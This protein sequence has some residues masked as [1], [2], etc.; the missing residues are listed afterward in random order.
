MVATPDSCPLAAS[1][2]SCPIWL[3][4]AVLDELSSAPLTQRVFYEHFTPSLSVQVPLLFQ[5]LG[6]RS[7]ELWL[8]NMPGS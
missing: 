6:L 7:L 8:T 5:E 2:M 1:L 3:S 4:L